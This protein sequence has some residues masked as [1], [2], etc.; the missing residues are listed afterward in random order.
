[1][2][3]VIKQEED[4]VSLKGVHERRWLCKCD[5]GNTKVVREG[6][7]LYDGTKSCGCLRHNKKHKY[8][9]YNLFCEYGIGYTSKG[10]E[11]YFDLEDYDKIKD[12]TWH[13]NDQGYVVARNKN[14]KYV[15][16]HRLVMYCPEN[17]FVDHIHGIATRNDNR[18]EN[19]R[20]CTAQ[21]N[22]RNSS[23]RRNNSS[24][25][26]GVCFDN[27]RN[28]WRAYIKVND[29]QVFLG[30]F[31]NF[32]DAAAARKE[33]EDKYFGEFSYDNSQRIGDL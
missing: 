21:Q 32:E 33:A 7:L 18:K 31:E 20:I 3:T 23:V 30:R 9:Q 12:Y 4:A 27:Y 8:N 11:F 29:K 5:C 1:M 6:N 19:L 2:L 13:I 15:R 14:K 26:T 28:K 24:G 17:Y 10:E 25:I 16:M 22:I